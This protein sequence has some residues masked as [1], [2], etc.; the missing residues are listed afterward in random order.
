MTSKRKR[1][2]IFAAYEKKEF[3]QD[4][5]IFYL[6]FLKKVADYIIV[7][8]DNFLPES[9]IEK[10][11]NFANYII[12]Y[13]HGEYDFGSYKRGYQYAAEKSI[14][15]DFDELILCNDSCFC[16]KDIS[17]CF[18][19]MEEKNYD[20][21]G[22]TEC[23]IFSKH[24]QSWFLVLK[25]NVFLSNVFKNFI[26]SVER[27]DNYIDV[28]KSYEVA[29]TGIL[30]GQGWKYASVN[31]HSKYKNPIFYPV[32][33]YKNRVY[34]LKKKCFSNY[35]ILKISIADAL[36]LDRILCKDENIYNSI[37]KCLNISCSIF[38]FILKKKVQL[39][40]F[41]KTIAEHLGTCKIK[42]FRLQIWKTKI[43]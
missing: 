28:V 9:E 39:F 34:F 3:V 13:A 21:W 42:I 10:L 43:R 2:A 37:R 1:I 36:K 17:P 19:K 5:V 27:K 26:S 4:Y 29:L 40:F 11:N 33:L 35:L 32:C 14:L 31:G 41:E 16:Y 15:N 30:S 25:K 24:L 23:E 38:S 18:K 22:M 6:N 8:Y 12:A 7:V 20:F